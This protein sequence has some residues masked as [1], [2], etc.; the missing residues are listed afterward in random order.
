MKQ[1]YQIFIMVILFFAL[2][3]VTARAQ[4][5]TISG[6]VSDSDGRGMPGVNV[7]VKGTSAGTTTNADGQYSISVNDGMNTL[8]FSFIGYATQEVDIGSRTSI[9]ITLLEDVSQLSEVVVTALGIERNTKAL[10][11]SATQVSGDNFTQARENNL[12]NALSGRVAGVNVSRPASGPAG[13]TRVIIR[14]NKSLNGQNQPLYVVD[15]IPITNATLGASDNYGQ[16][17]LWGGTDQGDGLTSLNPDDIESITVLKGANA[18]A[19][20]GSRGGNGVVNIVTKKGSAK[21]GLGIEFN[22][23]YVFENIIDLSDL[24]NKYGAGDLQGDPGVATRPSTVTQ[25]WE[26]GDLAWGTRMDGS[27]VIQSDGVSR[28]YSPAGNNFKRFFETGTAWTNSI[29]LSGGGEKQT[30]RFSVSDLRSNSIMPNSGFDRLNSSLSANSKFGKKITLDSKIMYSHE[31]A[32]NRP[33][34]SDSP[35]NAVQAVWRTPPSVNVLTFRGAPEKPGAI[36]VGYDPDLLI[37]LGGGVAANARHAGQELLPW[38]NIYLQNPYWSAYQYINSDDR[39][40]VIT[41]GQLRYDILDF[42]YISGRVG[43]DWYGKKETYLLPE[44]TAY[45]TAGEMAERQSQAREINMEWI[46]GF[47][48]TFNGIGVNAFVGGNRMRRSFERTSATG[49]GFNVQFFPAINNTQ[50]RSFNYIFN[51]SGINSLFASAEI[52]YKGLV[53]LTATARQDWFSVLNPDYN[54]ILYPSVG[55]S[56]VFSD[57]L[58]TLPTWL[59]FG[60]VRASWAQ[61]GLATIEPYASN[62]TYSFTDATHLGRPLATFSSALSNNGNIPNPTLQPALSSEIEFGAD[63]RFLDNRVS[64][65]VTYYSQT[66][67]DDILQATISRTT[68]FGT[69]SVNIGKLKNRGI[70]ILVGGTPVKGALT[71]DVSL[72]LARNKNK[73]VS[74]IEGITELVQEE[75]RSR[76]AFIKHIEGHPFGMITGKRQLLSPEGEPV[77]LDDGRPVAAPKLEPIGNGIADWTGG[78]NNAFTYKG[79]NLGFLIDFKIGGDILSSTN[80]RLTDWG[81][82]QQSL[83]GRDGEAPLTVEGVVQNGE[84]G[85][86]NPIYEPFTKTLTPQEARDYWNSVQ[87]EANP[88]PSMFMYDASFV[89]FRQLTLGYSLPRTWL[90]K[91]PFQTVSVSFV[92][93]NLFILHKNIDNIDPESSYSTNAGAQG[94]EYFAMPST[95]SYGFNVRIGL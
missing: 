45:N 15:G 79:I 66:T 16:A 41:S 52:D 13:S 86:G 25:A 39:D 43:M 18:A 93:R 4:Q 47:N 64:L 31:D 56:F 65:D 54:D 33:R 90:T 2:A 11:Y 32:K 72:N 5:R 74:L 36:P 34:L 10:Q 71:W 95:R 51:E 62:L 85:D 69:T 53:F 76:N 77:F 91:T 23:N 83:I 61:V 80:M 3:S 44:G 78:F 60:K 70:E 14:G 92:G 46:L 55:A 49:T 40:R 17:G 50:S 35:G 94:F 59:S 9:D 73:V 6:T 29:A 20:Y 88:I 63:V 12:G 1:R 38:S 42:L 75:P 7:I 48:K 37:M 21:R 30:F 19:L 82:H 8:V 27:P 58:K 28:P 68:G 22:S 26:M 67:T 84:D 81:L 57:A 87:G 89:K 24:Q